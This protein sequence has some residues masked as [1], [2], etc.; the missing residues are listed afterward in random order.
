[1]DAATHAPSSGRLGDPRRAVA[2]RPS[3]IGAISNRRAKDRLINIVKLGRRSY[4]VTAMCHAYLLHV[5][6]QHVLKLDVSMQG[7]SGVAWLFWGLQAL[8]LLLIILLLVVGAV[9]RRVEP[10]PESLPLFP[11]GQQHA[12]EC[13][14]HHEQHVLRQLGV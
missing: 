6:L 12:Q 5:C 2:R 8:Q 11:L 4:I 10:V 1:M 9:R 14:R 7:L 13:D 3:S